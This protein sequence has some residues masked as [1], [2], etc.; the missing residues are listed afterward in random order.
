MASFSINRKVGD[1]LY[2]NATLKDGV[3][4]GNMLTLMQEENW[5]SVKIDREKAIK[6]IGW[7]I[8]HEVVI[9]AEKEGI[10]I[11]TTAIG[12]QSWPFSQDKFVVDA[13]TFIHPEHRRVRTVFTLLNIM[14]EVSEY[15]DLPL[16]VGVRTLVNPED[17]NKLFSRF[18]KLVG[19]T[20]IHNFP[21]VS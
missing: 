8:K 15:Y 9:V 4:I 21:G 18:F 2:R 7:N 20:Y 13:W 3:A 5:P 12:L 19:G 1:V 11:A 14:K 17:K 16:F 6:W 10:L